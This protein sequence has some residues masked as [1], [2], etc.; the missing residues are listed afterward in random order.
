MMLLLLIAIF[1][2][3]QD[4]INKEIFKGFVKYVFHRFCKFIGFTQKLNIF[5][6]ILSIQAVREQVKLKLEKSPDDSKGTV[7]SCVAM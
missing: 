6:V 7:A 3:K 4:V 2:K 5:I 1:G